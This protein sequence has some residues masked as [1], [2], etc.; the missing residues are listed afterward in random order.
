M[1]GLGLGGVLVGSGR[2]LFGS[3]WE[4]PGPG[5]ELSGPGGGS[6][7]AGLRL[8]GTS[9]RVRL[10]GFCAARNGVSGWSAE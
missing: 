5:R 1:I 6:D 3:T 10:R 8:D 9:C 2:V 7:P 4:L